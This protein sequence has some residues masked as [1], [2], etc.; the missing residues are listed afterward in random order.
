MTSSDIATRLISKR[1]KILMKLN[2]L[3]DNKLT[4]ILQFAFIVMQSQINSCHT[5]ST[6]P[7]ATPNI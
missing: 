6:L 1:K 3:S 5:H 4:E 7:N 2:K